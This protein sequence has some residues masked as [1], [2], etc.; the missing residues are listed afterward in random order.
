M[1]RLHDSGTCKGMIKLRLPGVDRLRNRSMQSEISCRSARPIPNAAVADPLAWRPIEVERDMQAVWRT[2]LF[3]LRT[4][5]PA[6]LF[7]V[8]QESSPD[9]CAM[10][11]LRDI[12]RQGKGEL[13]LDERSS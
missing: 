3:A 6:P 13:G 1:E 12:E 9:S 7:D 2:G 8:S 10:Q 11:F 5:E 4:R